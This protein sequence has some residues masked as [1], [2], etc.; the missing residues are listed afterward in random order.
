[1]RSILFRRERT[2]HLMVWLLVLALVIVVNVVS[3]PTGY[4]AAIDLKDFPASERDDV[5]HALDFLHLSPL[6]LAWYW[7]IVGAVTSAISLIIGWLL[8]QRG[9]P[10]GFATYL[11]VVTVALAAAEYPP[12]IREIYPDRPVLQGI[13]LCLT[14]IGVS[15]LFILPLIFPDGRFVPRWTILVAVY[16]AGEFVVLWKNP[17]FLDSTAFEIVSTLLLIGILVGAPIYRYRRVS[18]PDQRRQTRWVMLGF[19][20]GL[21]AFFAGDAMMR[22]IDSSPTGIA[23]LIG[24]MILIQIGFNLPFLAVAAA[25]LFH[26][27]FDIDVIL[28]RT[29]IWVAMTIVVIGTYVGIVIGVGNLLGSDDSLVLSL[30]ATGLVAVAFQPIRDRIQR[31]VNRMLFG[32][33]DDPYAVLS[34]LGHFIE[35]TLN[36]SDLLPQIIQTTADSLRL[37]YAALF[38]DQPEGPVLVAASGTAP[39]ATVRF[40]LTYQGAS[41]GTLEVGN[42]TAGD[43]FT[44]ADKR[45]LSDLARQIGIAARTVSLANELQQSR[46]RIVMSREEERRRL[47]RDLHDGLGA[48][49]AALIIEAGNARRLIPLDPGEADQALLAL[50][51]ELRGAVVDIRRLV[52]GLRPPALDE[53]GLVGALR[54][55]LA[56][57]DNGNGDESAPLRVVLNADEPLPSLPAGTEVAAF[58]IV[59]EAVTNAVR[60]SHGTTVMVEIQVENACLVLSVTDDGNGLAAPGDGSGLGL[61][62][63]RERASELGGTCAAEAAPSGRGLQIRVTL[64]LQPEN[65]VAKGEGHDPDSHPDR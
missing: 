32:D 27:L 60:H 29:L 25:I 1:M 34:R 50:Q 52:L 26:N 62:S 23:Y 64:P 46:E 63:M 55:R 10:A 58:R 41:V 42:R 31:F 4:D 61:Q 53:I 28:S 49:L 8:V 51:A 33:R 15:G 44:D 54:A 65:D 7:I 35:D 40:P 59:E 56:R 21:P 47:R 18:T 16:V 22:S 19:V 24:F 36:P 43:V 11:A 5:L 48:Q 57:L 30:I 45:L 20:I 39:S 6:H 14:I 17:G 13:I 37:P 38:L 2:P 12:N 3:I 9:Q